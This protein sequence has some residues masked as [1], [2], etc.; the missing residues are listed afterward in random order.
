LILLLTHAGQIL[1]A[2]KD[3]TM[4]RELFR[5]QPA[6]NERIGVRT[7]GM[8]QEDKTKWLLLKTYDC[9]CP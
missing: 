7:E 9:F 4:L 1:R 3:Q 2:W 6:L 5:M 8:S